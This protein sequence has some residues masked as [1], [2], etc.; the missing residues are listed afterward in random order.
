MAKRQEKDRV[1]PAYALWNLGKE[2]AE[3]GKLV[4]DNRPSE[5]VY[6]LYAH[7]VELVLKAFVASKGHREKELVRLGH[8]LENVLRG[9]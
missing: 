8:D 7:A 9:G 5:V 4:E 2:F 6:Y 1:V 3:A